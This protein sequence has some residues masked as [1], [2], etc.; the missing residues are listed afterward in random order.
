M[1]RNSAGVITKKKKK[2]SLTLGG[3]P[4]LRKVERN[5]WKH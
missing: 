5:T 3:L 4:F 1:P 2:L